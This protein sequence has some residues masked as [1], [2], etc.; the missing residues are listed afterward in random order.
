MIRQDELLKADWQTLV[1]LDACRYDIFSDVVTEYNIKGNLQ[2]ADTEACRTS[3]WY[4]HHWGGE[5]KDTILVTAHP[6]P[7]RELIH[8]NFY[9]A[10]LV[11]ERMPEC[12][13]PEVTLGPT[14]NW[15]QQYP[16]KRFLV[17]L[18]PPHLP[19]LGPKGIEFLKKIGAHKFT[20]GKEINGTRLYN[21]IQEKGRLEGWERQRLCY[22]ENIKVALDALVKYLNILRPPIVISADHGEHIG[23]DG[24]YGHKGGK[25]VLRH[26]PWMEI[27]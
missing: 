12:L 15:Q 27:E 21:F 7:F 26:V 9:R 22:R 24:F 8:R 3:R 20:R 23:E 19:Y 18:L 13:Y 14:V 5:H 1:I 17:H 10:E 16:D 2:V 11:G 6:M 25:L 4:R